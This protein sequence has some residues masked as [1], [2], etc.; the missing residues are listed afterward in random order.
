MYFWLTWSSR[1]RCSHR[2]C[3]V[4]QCVLRNFAK[5]TGKHPCQ[6][7]FL[8]ES[9]PCNFI[10]KETLAQVFSCEFCKISKNTFFTEHLWAT[11][12]ITTRSSMSKV[13]R[14]NS[15]I[16]VSL[17]IF[18]KIYLFF[19]SFFRFFYSSCFA[20]FFL[21]KHKSLIKNTYST[22]RAG[23]GCNNFQ[24]ADFRKQD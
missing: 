24:P 4:R 7:L 18:H 21:I 20:V 13:H 11:A 17:Q 16:I 23:E 9:Q 22:M 10:K 14:A 3:N 15:H 19:F 2:R 5:L 6:S 12:S 1:D 8:I